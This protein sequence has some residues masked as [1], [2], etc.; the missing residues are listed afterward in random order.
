MRERES[1][2]LREE[3]TVIQTMFRKMQTQEKIKV[4]KK[5]WLLSTKA[6]NIY[7][8]TEPATK[9]NYGTYRRMCRFRGGGCRV[10]AC[11]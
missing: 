1:K 10:V 2:Y 4:K 7:K 5:T 9:P 3:K 6:W 8:K 11:T